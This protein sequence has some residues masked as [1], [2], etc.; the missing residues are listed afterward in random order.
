MIT[1]PGEAVPQEVPVGVIVDAIQGNL[2]QD[3]RQLPLVGAMAHELDQLAAGHEI[4]WVIAAV[5]PAW[6][7]LCLHHQET[8]SSPVQ[9]VVLLLIFLPWPLSVIHRRDEERH[10]KFGQNLPN[11]QTH[12]AVPGRRIERPTA[13]PVDVRAAGKIWR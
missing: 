12:G 2:H 4:D 7:V 11:R 13:E 5:P 10:W 1:R 6:G 8:A 3:L 9:A